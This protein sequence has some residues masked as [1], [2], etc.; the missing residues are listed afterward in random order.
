MPTT[1][2]ILFDLGDVA[3][4][5]LPERRLAAF[6]TAANL[7]ASEVSDSINTDFRGQFDLGGFGADEMCSMIRE[8]LRTDLP[9]AKIKSAWSAAFE[10]NPAVLDIAN[11]LQDRF[12]TGLL[13]NNPPL[14]LDAL[15]N[16]LPSVAATFAPIIFSFAHRAIK[17]NPDLYSAVTAQ[18]DEPPASILLID[19]S[20]PNINAAI[21]HGWQAIHFRSAEQLARDLAV[22]LD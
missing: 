17:P 16:H 14:L 8:T 20:E 4:H 22:I 15:P 11:K 10:P 21:E 1:S 9:D 7:T 6:A 13:T 19:D 3:C 18:L 5:F 12:V 2:I